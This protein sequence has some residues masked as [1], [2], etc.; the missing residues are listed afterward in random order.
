MTI[1]QFI[2]KAIEGGWRESLEID[3]IDFEPK[4]VH[5]NA[6]FNGDQ[7]VELYHA[8]MLWTTR[9]SS[10]LLDPDAWKAVGKVEGWNVPVFYLGEYA[11]SK[12]LQN[13]LGAMLGMVLALADGKTIEQ[14]LETL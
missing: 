6:D 4:E 14:Y 13:W 7:I 12:S 1:Q 10:I 8:D 9:T 5:G 11:H 3:R 2:E